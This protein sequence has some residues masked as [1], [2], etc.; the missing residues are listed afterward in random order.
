MWNAS[1]LLLRRLRRPGSSTTTDSGPGNS[2][3]SA[4]AADEN[5]ARYSGGDLTAAVM[6]DEHELLRVLREAI[7]LPA[8]M[9]LADWLV[10][11]AVDFY[12]Q[13][14]IMYAALCDL[15]SEA[16]C[17]SMLVGDMF[18][19]LWTVPEDPGA[20]PEKVR[21]AGRAARP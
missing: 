9:P 11:N 16:T 10:L 5:G 21:A 2:P 1:R 17:P 19:Y 7:R 3:G 8:D 4:A 12:N 15:C 18:E 14:N 13:V 20:A 6:S